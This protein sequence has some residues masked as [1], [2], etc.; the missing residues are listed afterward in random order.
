FDLKAMQ[1]GETV[2]QL[3]GH[4]MVGAFVDEHGA[5]IA[6]SYLDDRLSYAFADPALAPHFRAV[7][8]YFHNECNV[9][10]LKIDDDHKR[11]VLRASGPRDPGSFHVYHREGARLE[12]IGAIQPALSAERLAPMEA[13]KVK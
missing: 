10:I 8:S 1:F 2:A 6:S 3:P 7:N 5:L 11:L 12:Q 13:L 9:E 4:D